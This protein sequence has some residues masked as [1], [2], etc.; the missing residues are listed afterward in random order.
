MS[1]SIYLIKE[2]LLS[3]YK[4]GTWFLEGLPV[5]IQ[6]KIIRKKGVH[7]KKPETINFKAF[8]QVVKDT[9]IAKS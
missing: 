6:T 5:D 1:V 7:L 8:Y 3:K 9:Y 4:Q 2:G